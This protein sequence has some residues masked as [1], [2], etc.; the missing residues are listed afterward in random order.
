MHFSLNVFSKDPGP[1]GPAL[2]HPGGVMKVATFTSSVPRFRFA[3]DGI[4]DRFQVSGVRCQVSATEVDRWIGVAH[5][6]DFLSPVLTVSPNPISV[7][8][9]GFVFTDT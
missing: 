4:F 9:S 6:M 1:E 7:Q 8:N 2:V 3:T 5:E